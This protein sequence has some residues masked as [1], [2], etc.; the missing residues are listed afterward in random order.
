MGLLVFNR[1]GKKKFV[2]SYSLGVGSGGK[3][4]KVP[5]MKKKKTER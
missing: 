1:Q 2:Y 4:T 3:E 5:K